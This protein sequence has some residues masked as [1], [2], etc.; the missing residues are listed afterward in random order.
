VKRRNQTGYTMVELMMALALL[1][2]GVLGIVA[3]QRVTVVSNGHAKRLAIAQRIAQ[4]WAT[5][6]QMDSSV[7]RSNGALPPLISTP[8][9]QWS[10]PPE[11]ASRVGGAFDALGAPLADTD[12]AQAAFCTHVRLSWLYQSSTIGG[13]DLL[14]AEIRVF[15]RR[16]GHG[17]DIDGIGNAWLKTEGLCSKAQDAAR[18]TAIGQDTGTFHFLYQTVG[19]RQHSQI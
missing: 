15:W 19:I 4:T 2:V 17:S 11:V 3:L 16:D 1:T 18:V 12:A 6:L 10:R 13:S 5:Q 7:W 9:G 14:R 8:N